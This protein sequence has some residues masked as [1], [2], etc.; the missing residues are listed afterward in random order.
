MALVTIFFAVP[1]LVLAMFGVNIP[2]R[3]FRWGAARTGWSRFICGWRASASRCK[4]EEHIGHGESRVY[5]C[6]HVSWCDDL[7]ARDQHPALSHRGQDGARE[8][9][10]VR[11]GGGRGRG[12]LHRSRR[13]AGQAFAAYEASGAENEG[14]HVGRA[15]SPR[16]RADSTM[17]CVRSRRARSCSRSRRRCRW[18][19][20]SRHG[21]RARSSRRGRSR[22]H[23]HP[24]ELTF[25]GARPHRGSHVRRPR[26]THRARLARGWRTNSSGRVESAAAAPRC[27]R[28]G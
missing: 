21:D 8:D 19:P 9:P 14:R 13:T 27:R 17:S 2:A 20:W 1:I 12:D 16:G 25:S 28:A 22:H 3:Q 24:I 4:G 7:R 15:S 11:A 23:R 18:C 10:A 6:N 26:S 5:M